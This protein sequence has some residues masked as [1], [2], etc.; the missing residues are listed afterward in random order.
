MITYADISAAQ[1]HLGQALQLQSKLRDYIS[2]LLFM[3]TVSSRL[4]CTLA[5]RKDRLI[6]HYNELGAAITAM[7]QQFEAL[8]IELDREE[9][10][11]SL[12]RE[13]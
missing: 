9:E 10:E 12:S 8:K 7:A 11:D 5:D 1:I 13:D 4:S 3:D 6:A 2:D